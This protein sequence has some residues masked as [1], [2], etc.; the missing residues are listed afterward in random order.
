[1]PILSIIGF[2]ALVGLATVIL[3]GSMELVYYFRCLFERVNALENIEPKLMHKEGTT[4]TAIYA[5]LSDLEQKLVELKS[6]RS[7]K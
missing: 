2:G 5:R 1:M 3:F 4:V 6:K 7:S